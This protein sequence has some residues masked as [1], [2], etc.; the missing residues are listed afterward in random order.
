[1]HKATPQP[2]QPTLDWERLPWREQF[3]QRLF[4]ADLGQCKDPFGFRVTG[5]EVGLTN[6]PIKRNANSVLNSSRVLVL[7][8]PVL[9]VIT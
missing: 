3:L 2:E 7:T 1:M 6:V 4:G 5:A 8:A 9:V